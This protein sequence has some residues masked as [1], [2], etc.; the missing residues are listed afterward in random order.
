MARQARIGCAPNSAVG[1]YY[2]DLLRDG[3]IPAVSKMGMSWEALD[4]SRPSD[5]W[6]M[7][8]T[9]LLDSDNISFIKE[10]LGN[11]TSEELLLAGREI[12]QLVL[13]ERETAA[14]KAREEPEQ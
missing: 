9:V 8:P 4:F 2:E 7:D 3:G 1:Q 14:A 12:G 10:L 6:C 11:D 13:D 5:I